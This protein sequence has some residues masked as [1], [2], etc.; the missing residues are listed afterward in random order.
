MLKQLCL[1]ANL[2]LNV[3]VFEDVCPITLFLHVD[4][5]LLKKKNYSN[6]KTDNDPIIS[7]L[8][9]HDLVAETNSSIVP[10]STYTSDSDSATDI[11]VS[12]SGVVPENLCMAKSLA[13]ADTDGSCADDSSGLVA[14]EWHER[15]PQPF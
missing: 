10:L 13:M 1:R 14:K 6:H 9:D 7:E 15:A 11:S 2:P 5:L 4:S 3:K 8:N 12:C